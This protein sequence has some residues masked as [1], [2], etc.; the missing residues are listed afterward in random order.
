MIPL[1]ILQTVGIGVLATILVIVIRQYR[2]EIALQLSLVVGLI[3]FLLVL[4][5]IRPII[6]VIEQL[7]SQANINLVY[8]GT[9]LKI[10]A[11][12]YITEFGAQICRDADVGII[13][14]KIELAGKVLITVLAI[15]I[16]VAIMETI[17]KLL[18]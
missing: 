14:S 4:G 10:V 5:Q 7:S 1:E 6:D 8:L 3:I 12:A 2:P 17:M 13:A 15:P 16:L 11:I 18:N 9:I